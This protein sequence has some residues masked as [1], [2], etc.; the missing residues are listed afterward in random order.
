VIKENRVRK[1][2]VRALVLFAAG[3]L[4]SVSTGKFFRSV[5]MEDK[6]KS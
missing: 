2:Q 3:A 1:L 5:K 4:K 6:K